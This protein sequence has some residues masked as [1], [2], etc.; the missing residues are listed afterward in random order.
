MNVGQNVKIGLMELLSNKLRSFLT[1]LGVV[2]G[3]AAVVASVAIG[4]GAKR[5]AMNQ[6]ASMG[7]NN[8]KIRPV[9][10][11][12]QAAAKAQ[13]KNPKGL[14]RMDMEAILQNCGYVKSTAPVIVVDCKPWYQGQ[15]ITANVIATSSDYKDI[16]NMW[17]AQGRYISILD[18]IQA[19]R[20]C[21]LGSE[22]ADKYLSNKNPI[23]EKIIIGD[24]LY[25]VIGIVGD[26]HGTGMNSKS[27]EDRD[28]RKDIYIPFQAALKRFPASDSN[29]ELS[30][31]IVKIDDRNHI[32]IAA[33]IIEKILLRRH[34]QIENYELIIPLELLKQSQATQRTFNLVLAAIAGISLLVGG[35]GIMN[36]MLASVTQRTREVGIRRAL[37]AKKKDI[38]GQFLIESVVL[39]LI[40]GLIGILVGIIMGFIIASYAGWMTVFSMK[41][42][43]LSVMVSGSVGIIFG[44]FPARRAA[45]LNPIE[46]LRYE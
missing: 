45:N 31:I 10:L 32:M 37:G 35:I 3:V 43:L 36:I 4:E 17:V 33:S 27:M 2:F 6:I 16:H 40:G 12:G 39:S 30:E 28:N 20:V 21:V 5:E 25:T 29:N 18:E 34:S 38:L 42:I 22:I 24:G 11:D 41:A 23:Q 15:P 7:I 8:I 46:A 13:Q 26:L 14:N 19:S 44:L 9:I 1:T